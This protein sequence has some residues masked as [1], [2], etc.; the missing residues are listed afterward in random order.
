MWA[1]ATAAE[2]TVLSIESRP[3]VSEVMVLTPAR[4]ANEMGSESVAG[5]GGAKNV[6][7][8]FNGGSGQIWIG[9]TSDGPD[10][11]KLKRP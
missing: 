10:A 2:E 6:V 5:Q 4:L 1:Q 7:I 3:G 9:K 11:G 8:V